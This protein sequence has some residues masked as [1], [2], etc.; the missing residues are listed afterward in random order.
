MF[1]SPARRPV[2]WSVAL[3]PPILGCPSLLMQGPV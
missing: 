2:S 3:M 1:T